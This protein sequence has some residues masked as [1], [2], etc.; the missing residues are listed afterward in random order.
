MGMKVVCTGRCG[1]I[2][3]EKPLSEASGQP[4]AMQRESG[5]TRCPQSNA[6]SMQK[7]QA[8]VA[9]LA[10]PLRLGAQ[11]LHPTHI[12]FLPMHASFYY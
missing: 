11:L 8:P 12:F 10:D 6:T 3:Q 7:H 5:C 4:V 9:F 1:M 2:S